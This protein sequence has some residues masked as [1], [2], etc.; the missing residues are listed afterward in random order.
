MTDARMGTV[1]L[2]EDHR[3]CSARAKNCTRPAVMWFEATSGPDD[4][5]RYYSC[6]AHAGSFAYSVAFASS[7]GLKVV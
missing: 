7:A 4:G 6:E 3:T 5:T 2:I 1:N